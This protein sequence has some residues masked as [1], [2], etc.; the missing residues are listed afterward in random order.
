MN[1]ILFAA[2]A[3]L[4]ILLLILSGTLFAASQKWDKTFFKKLN[5][6][7]FRVLFP[8]NLFYSVYSIETLSVINAKMILYI[9]GSTFVCMA[10][11]WVAAAAFIPLREQKSVIIQAAFR[12]NIAVIGLAL[13]ASVSTANKAEA[14]AFASLSICVGS[15]INNFA[16]V[17]LLSSYADAKGGIKRK[18]VGSL[19]NPLVVGSL[20]GLA[21]LCIRPYIGNFRLSNLFPSAFSAIS[22]LSKAS[23]PMAL[24]CLGGVL[25]FGAARGI[26]K[27][28]TIG[29]LLR[30]LI[31]PLIVIGTAVILKGPLKLTTIEMPGLVAYTAAP[32]A[33]SSAIMVQEMGGDTQLANHLV[34]WSSVI[35]V[36]TLFLFIIALKSI[37]ML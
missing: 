21:C 3:V 8:V 23:S 34:V 7:V 1:N 5:T 11:G 19:T 15:I 10:I 20:L 33:I 36:F 28:I 12:S 4:P 32:V 6:V 30:L 22:S 17:C 9:A 18:L 14:S 16:A 29:I 27:S 31:C 2:K 35:S 13:V 37:G 26:G 25:D 24:F